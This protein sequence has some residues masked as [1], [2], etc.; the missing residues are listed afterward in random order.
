MDIL[1]INGPNLNL[2]GTREPEIYGN[3]TLDQIEKELIQIAKQNKFK[4]ECYQSNHEGEILD[5]IQ[6]SQRA[7]A[8]LRFFS[9]LFSGVLDSCMQPLFMVVVFY[10]IYY[11]QAGTVTYSTLRMLARLMVSIYSALVAIIKNRESLAEMQTID[12][13]SDEEKN[14]IAVALS[15]TGD[16]TRAKS[17][18]QELVK[19]NGN[20]EKYQTTNIWGKKSGEEH[21]I[22]KVL[23]YFLSSFFGTLA[24]DRTK[25]FSS[26]N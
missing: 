21:K 8:R 17:L 26:T 3:Q 12:H 2:L 15:V 23:I 4:L 9:D 25:N 16:T 22:F 19:A 18:L 24:W 20:S 6:S 13:Y 10:S 11:T 7:I 1:L 14:L 5:K